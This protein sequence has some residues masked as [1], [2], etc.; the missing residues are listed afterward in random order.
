VI[1]GELE[2]LDLSQNGLESIE[3]LEYLP[4][5][6]YVNLGSSFSPVTPFSFGLV[7]DES[8]HYRE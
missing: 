3:G 8:T 2:Y 6:T 5:V 4:S 1:R 7:V